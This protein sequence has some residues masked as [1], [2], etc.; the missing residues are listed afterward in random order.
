[1]RHRLK[2]RSNIQTP[3]EIRSTAAA[4]PSQ[5]HSDLLRPEC[6][7]AQ[8]PRARRSRWPALVALPC[9]A[10]PVPC[11]RRS[12]PP[13]HAPPLPRATQSSPAGQIRHHPRAWPTRLT[14]SG[15]KL[16]YS[17]PLLS[18]RCSQRKSRRSYG[19]AGAFRAVWQTEPR[20]SSWSRS[21]SAT[22]HDTPP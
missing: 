19:G 21:G 17:A 20:N 10:P 11:R 6:S 22:T 8:R 9:A 15:E 5:P 18:P 7:A 13:Q 1:M 12:S 16:V 4:L 14:R 3:P 2:F